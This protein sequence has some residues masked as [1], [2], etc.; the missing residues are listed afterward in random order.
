MTD[1]GHARANEH[2]INFGASHIGK[3][4][5]I[6]RIVGA[7]HDR[8][9]DVGQVNFDN[10]CIV[11]IG[12]AL[13]Q[14]RIFQPGFHRLNTAVDGAHV[15]VTLGN[16]PLQHGDVAGDVLLNGLLV[17]VHRATAST[18]LGRCIAEFKSLLYFEIRQAFNFQNATREDIFLTLLGHSQQT[19]FDG[20]Q[21]D[22]IDQITQGDTGLHLAFKAHQHTLRHIQRHHA[23]GGAES[24][25]TGACREA[26]TNRKAG[27]AVATGTH[28]IGQQ[29]AVEPAVDDA[30]TRTQGHTATGADEVWQLVV[31]LHVHRLG[32]GRRMAE[33]L[34]HQ[35]GTETQAGQ[36]FQFI[37][38]HGAGGVLRTHAG[39]AGL[40]VSARANALLVAR[41]HRQT[42]GAT[43]HFLRQG[44]PFLG[45]HRVLWQAEKCTHGQAQRLACLGSETSANDQRNTAT[46]AHFIKQHIALEFELSDNRTIFERFAVIRTQLNH[47]AH[48]HLAHVQLNG[49]RARVFH[50][51]VKN[52]RDFAAQAHAAESLVGH[53]R[54]VFTREPQHRVGG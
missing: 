12:I 38:G 39:H 15:G 31:H 23:S 48:E 3:C 7:S 46:G 41:H 29:H 17:Q 13:E 33:R 47:I 42:T 40:A 22:R 9:M 10:G 20:V 6:V 53:K 54:N 32:V 24:N 52:R 16:H 5:H 4:F 27:V 36:V 43:H 28:G 21:R 14:L 44:E 34:H 49:Q 30:V 11:S 1:I 26:N 37:T 2:L 25:K 8:F 18:A 51:V 45:I 35:V 50:G 19:G